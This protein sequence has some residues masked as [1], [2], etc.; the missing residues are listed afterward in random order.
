MKCHCGQ[1]LVITHTSEIKKN[2]L[3]YTIYLICP[4]EKRLWRIKDYR[5]VIDEDDMEE[6]TE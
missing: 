3:Y 6:I 2:A 5:Y 1:E 4:K